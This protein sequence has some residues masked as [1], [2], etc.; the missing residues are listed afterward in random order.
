MKTKDGP[1]KVVVKTFVSIKGV[2]L[3]AVTDFKNL[4]SQS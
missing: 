1:V 4:N 2:A 3:I